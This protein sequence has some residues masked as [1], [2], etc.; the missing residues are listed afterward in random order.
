MLCDFCG[1]TVP[2]TRIASTVRVGEVVVRG[3]K[4]NVY[5]QVDVPGNPGEKATCN[6]CHRDAVLRFLNVGGKKRK[7]KK[8]KPIVKKKKK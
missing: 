5:I 1:Q 4:A 6:G 2:P 8:K 7:A 3:K